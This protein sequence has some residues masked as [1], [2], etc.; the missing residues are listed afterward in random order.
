MLGALHQA[1]G[2][3]VAFGT[4]AALADPRFVRSSSIQR[5]LQVNII[6]FITAGNLI[7]AGVTLLL[8]AIGAAGWWVAAHPAEVQAIFSSL[9]GQP[10]VIR[11]KHRYRTYIECL[12]RRFRP[13][14]AFG[15]SC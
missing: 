3:C 4:G 13:A 11:A 14:G 2:T 15:L 6:E 5:C 7:L 10:R 8:V 9:H 12:M 1:A